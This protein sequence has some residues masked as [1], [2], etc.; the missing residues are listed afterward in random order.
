MK[1]CV[2]TALAWIIYWSVFLVMK[3]APNRLI[4]IKLGAARGLLRLFG[5]GQPAAVMADAAKIFKN[6]QSALLARR[7][8]LT[9]R[10]G[11]VKALIRGALW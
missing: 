1:K 8:I 5:A 10:P 6:P 4:V 7:M 2:A 3:Y 11:Q 9:S